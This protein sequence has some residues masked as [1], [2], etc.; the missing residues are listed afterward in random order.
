MLRVARDDN[1]LGFD[2]FDVEHLVGTTEAVAFVEWA[3]GLGGVEGDDADFTAAGFGKSEFDEMAGELF[4]AVF[5]LDIDIEQVGAL[6]GTRVER[7]RRPVE[8]HESRSGDNTVSVAGKPADVFAVLDG[9]GDPRLEVADHDVEDLVVGAAGID[10]HAAAV[11]GDEGSVG[12]PGRSGFQHG[13]KY[14]TYQLKKRPV[15]K[16]PAKVR[17]VKGRPANYCANPRLRLRLEA[18]LTAFLLSGVS[19]AVL[20]LL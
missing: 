19:R 7:M 20:T 18:S 8:D 13:E 10:K 14:R 9:F 12:G 1:L 11:M 15:V 16:R 4:A 6:G 5:R 2:G 17:S 3:S